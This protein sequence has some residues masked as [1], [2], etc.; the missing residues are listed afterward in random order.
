MKE[1]EKKKSKIDK[2]VNKYFDGKPKTKNNNFQQQQ[3]KQ[4]IN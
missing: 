4:I 2:K 3:K 1:E